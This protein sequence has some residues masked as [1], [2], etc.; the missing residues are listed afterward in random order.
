MIPVIIIPTS[1]STSLVVIT[2]PEQPNP[3]EHITTCK[4]LVVQIPTG[5]GA[6]T[7]LT[8]YRR[9]RSAAGSRG[10]RGG[11]TRRPAATA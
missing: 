1:A 2:S 9:T 7:P 3:L 8:S 4:T 5:D 6:G 10:P 11:R